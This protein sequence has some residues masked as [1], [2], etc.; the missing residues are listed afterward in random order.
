MKTVE[1]HI[2][3][4]T[5]IKLP[6]LCRSKEATKE[7]RHMWKFPCYFPLQWGKRKK[8]LLFFKISWGKRHETNCSLDKTAKL[9]IFVCISQPGPERRSCQPD[10]HSQLSTGQCSKWKKPVVFL[11]KY[12][13]WIILNDPWL[14]RWMTISWAMNGHR[15]RKSLACCFP[16]SWQKKRKS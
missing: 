10:L 11:R 12:W 4:P 9:S 1:L 16:Q 13:D 7:R 6:I 8:L 14:S 15:S 5:I 2:Y 3:S